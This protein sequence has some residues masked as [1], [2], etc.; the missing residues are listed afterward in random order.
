MALMTHWKLPYDKWYE[1]GLNRINRRFYFV[2]RPGYPYVWIFSIPRLKE[3]L[4]HGLEPYGGH[5]GICL[6]KKHVSY[7]LRFVKKHPDLIDFYKHTFAP[8]EM[9]FETILMNS[10]LKNSVINQSIR[11]DDFSEGKSHPKN[12]TREDLESL[13]KSGKL[14]ARK[15]NLSVDKDIL[16]ID[17]EIE[18]I[19]SNS[20]LKS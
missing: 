3:G 11:Y 16:D 14:F 15:F 2:P 18:R 9:F 13:R 20:E 5:G 10:P 12:L 19:R 8:D 1:G 6:Q 4:P 17:K 7:I